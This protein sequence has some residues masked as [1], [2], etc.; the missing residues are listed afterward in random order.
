VYDTIDRY[1]YRAVLGRRRML[2]F[3]KTRFRSL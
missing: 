3:S 1:Y 2:W